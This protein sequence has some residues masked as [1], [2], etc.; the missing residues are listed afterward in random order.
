MKRFLPAVFLFLIPVLFSVSQAEESGSPPQ[1]DRPPREDAPSLAAGSPEEAGESPGEVS[2]EEISPDGEQ[3]EEEPED[4]NAAIIRM[5]INT[6]TFMELA[7]WCRS[8]G[9]SEGGTRDELANRLRS[10][11]KLPA[12]GGTISSEAKIITIE[13]A[14][15]T[16]YFTLD[17]VDEEYA[18]L[19]GDVVISLKD[20]EAVHRVKA[21]EILYNRTRNLLTASGGVE[22]VKEEGDTIET[23]KGDSIVV[24]LDNWSSI[25]VDG[26]SERS[27]SGSET[28]YRFAGTVISRSGEEVTVLTGAEITNATNEEAF[29]SLNASKLWLL[30][31]SD[32][33]IFNAVLKVG[34]I[35]VLYLPFFFYPSDEIVFHPVVGY[36][37]REGTFL[38]TTTYILGRPKTTD[39]S[40]N[41]L[42]KI[43]GSSSDME[44]TREGVFLRSTGK[45]YRDPNDTRLSVI[46][47]AYA[48]LGAYLGT[49]MALPKIGSFGATDLSFGLGFTRNVYLLPYGNSPF[50][51]YDGKSDWNSSRLFSFDMPFRYRFKLTGSY[52]GK[53]GSFSLNF[54][55]YSDPYVDQDFLN[56][57]ETLDWL[58]MI[59]EG[60][61]EEEETTTTDTIMS[62]YEWRLNGSLSP[63]VSAFSP[64]LS[65]LSISSI[66][67]ALSFSTRSSVRY[68][69]TPDPARVFFFPN[70]FTLYS[71]N[72][73]A[74]GTPFT[75]GGGSP[76]PAAGGQEESAA[77]GD[78]LLPAP[79][80]SPWES[81]GP[82]ETPA[83]RSPTD[84]YSLTPPVLSQTFETGASGSP[85]LAFDY[86]LSPSTASELQFRSSQTNWKEA[87]DIDWS[88]VSSVLSRIR[89]DASV[90]LTLSQTGHSIAYSNS[91]RLSG[92]GT[93]QDYMF[94][95]EDAEEFA[96]TGALKAARDRAYNETYF[97]SS[98]EYGATFQ[99]LYFSPTWRNSNLQYNVK[100]LF[101]KTKVDTSGADPDWDMV[102]GK[103]N[104]EDLDTHQ[105]VTNLA[106]SVRDYNQNLSVTAVLP[107]EDTSLAGNATFRVWI[108]ETN[109]RGRILNPYEEEKR[110]FEPVYVTETLKFGGAGSFQQYL[111]YDPE[112]EEFTTLTSSLSLSGLTASY[113]AVYDWS[114][115]FVPDNP[116]APT[117]WTWAQQTGAGKHLIPREFRMAYAKTFK[118]EG[119]W[120]NRLSFSV[121]LN[122]GV[123]FNLQQYTSS[124]Y[125]FSLGFTTGITNF[126]DVTFSTTSEN[127]QFFRY[128]SNIP[129]F[130]DFPKDLYQNQE[131]NLF[132]DLLNSFRFDNIELRR[133]SGFKL[134]SFSLSL[135]HH[136][137]DW[138]ATLTMT[139]S[140]YLDQ[141]SY[142]YTYKFNNEI[143]FLVQWVPIT[144]IKTDIRYDKEKL[145]FK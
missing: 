139:L 49:E 9:L 74:A 69:S 39:A 46:F 89:S 116:A 98:W 14:R 106:A 67:S 121:N 130:D 77:P 20:G 143:A 103:W 53:Y 27:V 36:R 56:R 71:I 101:A 108:S 118:T 129:F 105:V 62:S 141:T 13:S 123:G 64:Y 43:F 7:S 12:E 8:L 10:H 83:D 142:P 45:K 2:P 3:P 111:V 31:G 128:F 78:A 100:G 19:R 22:Y 96:A 92:T 38:Q 80:R 136:L 127:A 33:A 134:K 119:L 30:P 122:T 102:Y 57:S 124:R 104:K 91:F 17:I 126:L 51:N 52:S 76:P 63:N 25:F 95:N 11:Y 137:G 65:S 18:R 131:T 97:T 21:W 93:W 16:E 85:K 99:P 107:P 40:E 23:F 37:S 125:N 133:S 1:E 47:D 84:A 42:T 48:N 68:A 29:W 44:K 32:W 88:E 41:S 94:L 82:E 113:T 81:A 34:N 75:L 109:A 59:R 54:P 28:A 135:I 26:V 61:A 90:G 132:V 60:S 4:P 72:A 112:I 6:S 55:H 120:D 66:S 50:A 138:N 73:A 87:E 24:N 110:S 70:R 145:T 79:P 144:E 58:G 86:R 140:P 117:R 114:Y 5:D 35:P 15:T 115:K